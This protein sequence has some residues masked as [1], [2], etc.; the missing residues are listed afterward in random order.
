MNWLESVLRATPPPLARY[1][2]VLTRSHSCRSLFCSIYPKY[3]HHPFQTLQEYFSCGR[4]KALVSASDSLSTSS[5]ST[6]M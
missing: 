3:M 6:G 4:L 5:V 2:N 1:L